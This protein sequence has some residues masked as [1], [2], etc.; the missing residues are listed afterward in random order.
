MNKAIK[1]IEANKQQLRDI[2]TESPSAALT[3]RINA[4]VAITTAGYT[5]PWSTV[6]RSQ[7]FTVSGT[8]ITFP[9]AG[10]YAIG[11]PVR[12]SVNNLYM[13]CV[14]TINTVNVVSAVISTPAGSNQ[15]SFTYN[16]MR[17]F[18]QNDVMTVII[19]PQAN[20]NYV[21]S[22]ENAAGASGYIYIMQ[23]SGAIE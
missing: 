11:L 4:T 15:T 6:V 18:R 2:N 9:T 14:L 21:F 23:L 19:T 13:R 17:H 5:I 10:F 12:V 7:A 3:A 22:G 1:N 20:A 16:F 8:Q